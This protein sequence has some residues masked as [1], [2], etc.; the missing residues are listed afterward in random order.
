M[1]NLRLRAGLDW[2]NRTCTRIPKTMGPDLGGVKIGLPGNGVPSA[3]GNF[4]DVRPELPAD[5]PPD[6]MANW[7]LIKWLVGGAALLFLLHIS[8]R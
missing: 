3:S 6:I 8:R 7:W 5:G 1:D 2:Q 4:R